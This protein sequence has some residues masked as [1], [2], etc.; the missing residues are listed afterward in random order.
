MEEVFHKVLALSEAQAQSHGHAEE[1]NDDESDV[2]EED[3][4]ISSDGS[5]G[6]VDLLNGNVQ[7]EGS[8]SSSISWC[9]TSPINNIC[10][11]LN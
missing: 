3:N 6:E 11:Y 8:S 7:S 1:I 5:T 2:F 10:R 4:T 9:P